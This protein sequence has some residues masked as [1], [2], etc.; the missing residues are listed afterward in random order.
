MAESF[1]FSLPTGGRLKTTNK[2]EWPQ[3]GQCE[4]CGKECTTRQ[5]DN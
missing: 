3:H 4:L 5:A 1:K 2:A